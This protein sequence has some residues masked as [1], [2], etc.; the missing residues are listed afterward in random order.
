MGG[1]IVGLYYLSLLA[2]VTAFSTVPITLRG[3]CFPTKPAACRAIVRGTALSMIS[4]PFGKKPE[5]PK[6]P[7]GVS[8]RQFLLPL[9]RCV[10]CSS[11]SVCTDCLY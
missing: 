1:P 11:A 7:W 10:S 2:S 5:E 4:N 3:G 9:L 8:A 6:K